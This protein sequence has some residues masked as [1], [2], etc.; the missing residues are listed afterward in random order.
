MAHGDLAGFVYGLKITVFPLLL[1]FSGVLM[2]HF[3]LKLDRVTLFVFITIIITWVIQYNQGID[4][5][6]AMG[7]EYGV[8]VKN[9]NHATPRLP[10]SVGTPDGY[11]FLL[12]ITGILLEY[13][14]MIRN[15]KKLKFIIKIVTLTFLILATIRSALVFWLVFQLLMSFYYVKK[16]KYR[17]KYLVLSI[18]YMLFSTIPIAIIYLSRSSLSS[19]SSLEDRLSHWGGNLQP[20]WSLEGIVGSGLGSVGAA[21]RR[22][23]TLG[24]QSTN[25]AVDNQFIAFYEQLGAIG[26]FCLFSIFSILLFMI[27]Y[28]VKKNNSINAKVAHCLMVCTFISGFFTNVLE[29][30]PF[31]LFLWIYIGKALYKI[32][33]HELEKEFV[34]KKRKKIRK[35]LVW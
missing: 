25:Y 32:P 13:S 26:T 24:Y 1:I 9:F 10:S 31:N 8:Q 34:I 22:T 12:C 15:K 35:K 11:A 29:L 23:A 28:N 21:S 3:G 20:I 7:W 33:Q 2:T 18:Y 17:V 14:T 5:L 6:V 16:L 30:Y 27:I 19:T 4:A